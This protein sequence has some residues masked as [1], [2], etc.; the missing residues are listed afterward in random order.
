[1]VWEGWTGIVDREI[2]FYDG[3]S[4]TQITDNAL[5]DYAPQINDN[6]QVVWEENDG[7]DKEIFLASPKSNQ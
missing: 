1:V 3:T 6:G 4:T 2:F 7:S 5:G